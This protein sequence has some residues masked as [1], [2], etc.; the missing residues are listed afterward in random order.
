M[1]DVRLVQLGVFFLAVL[2]CSCA[3]YGFAQAAGAVG[4]VQEAQG[5]ANIMRGES[6]MPAKPGMAIN[7]KDK[8]TTGAAS[9]LQI[10]FKDR[11]ILALAANSECHIA[12]V[13]MEKKKKPTFFVRLFKGTASFLS[14]AIKELNPEGFKVETPN[15]SLGIRG[16]EFASAVDP[17]K[18]VH[19]LYADGPLLVS[20]KN[21][22]QP[23]VAALPPYKKSQLCQQITISMKATN[24]A[25]RKIR[26]K[27]KHTEAKPYKVKAEAYRKLLRTY[28]CR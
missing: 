22:P 1:K 9:R 23:G 11:T 5:Q 8:V 28:Q 6:A 19:G 2:F 21:P 20:A 10:M 25:Y 14:G 12:D 24:L 4:W 13:F 26:S 18:E 17:G 7:N 16:T 15:A 27:G 3:S